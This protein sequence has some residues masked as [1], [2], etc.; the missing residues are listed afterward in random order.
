[1]APE[2]TLL[3]ESSRLPQEA[4]DLLS[5][6]DLFFLSTSNES[7]DMDS[8]IRGGPP[9]FVRMA[10]NSDAGAVIV[11]PEYSGNRLYSTLGNMLGTPRAG[12]VFPDFDTG[13]VLY[14]T[15]TTQVLIGLDADEVLPRSNL[16]VKLSI[17]QARLC[18][19]GCRL[20][21]CTRSFRRTTLI[22]VY[23]RP[24]GMSGRPWK[25]NKPRRQISWPK[26]SSLR[27]SPG[28]PSS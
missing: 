2:A 3:S 11:W 8:N 12:L 1:M 5:H 4:L 9:G 20:G 28:T 10:S 21:E 16:A 24:R 13:D 15:G 19:V 23:W 25:G 14:L 27:Q 18:N 26:S 6:A 7:K 22:C 17:E